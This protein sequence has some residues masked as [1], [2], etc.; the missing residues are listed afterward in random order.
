MEKDI[1]EQL[2]KSVTAIKNK[3][4]QMH[5]EEQNNNLTMNKIFK[6]VTTPL[7][8]LVNQK[9]KKADKQ[10]LLTNLDN[11][12]ISSNYQDV[13]D[14][15]DD[16][17]SST[18]EENLSSSSD[19]KKY[20]QPAII[21]NT[22]MET[23]LNKSDL[24]DLYESMNIP[25][26]VR[27][28]NKQFMIG[29]SFVKFSNNNDKSCMITIDNKRYE[30]TPGLKELLLRKTP[31]LKLV[32]END[33]LLYK[34]ILIKTNAHKRDFSTTG[35][36]KGDKG[37][38]YRDIIKPL[39]FDNPTSF[40]SGGSLPVLK[41]YK[42]NTDLVYW[43]DPNE[44]IERLKLLVASRDAG[45]ANHSNEIISIIEELKEAGIIKQ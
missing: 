18:S 39:F 32:N 17:N 30:L 21:P 9:C 34:D 20:I 25:F 41:V 13:E 44:L 14:I 45:N 24:S 28:E 42:K 3:I 2:V 38:K 26:G 15:T 7:Q 40:K 35:Q 37:T 12:S 16:D 10:N 31:D 11:Q 23:S 27:S 29:K 19:N 33:K 4:K 8:M 5:E 36:I 1:K 22:L 43:D 6:P